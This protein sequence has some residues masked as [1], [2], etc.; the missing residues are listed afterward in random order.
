[1]ESNST[2]LFAFM[3]RDESDHARPYPVAMPIPDSLSDFEF[4]GKAGQHCPFSFISITCAA[5]RSQSTGVEYTNE[6]CCVIPITTMVDQLPHSSFWVHQSLAAN[7]QAGRFHSYCPQI[8]GRR[9]SSNLV[10]TS[11]FHKNSHNSWPSILLKSV[12]SCSL[13][14]Q[15]A[16]L[17][18]GIASHF[19]GNNVGLMW[20]MQHPFIDT[21]LPIFVAVPVIS[22]VQ[23]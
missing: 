8:L 11:R 23:L 13:L 10:N 3:P 4:M 2:F 1:M 5:A 6:G 16:N 9:K 14:Q 22:L 19:Y 12:M 15:W 17:D 21:T 18:D 7:A 20:I